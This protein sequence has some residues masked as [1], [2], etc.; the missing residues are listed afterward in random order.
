MRISCIS[1]T[2]GAQS[3][4]NGGKKMTAQEQFEI[5][6][7]DSM[8]RGFP[9]RLSRSPSPTLS[10]SNNSA[11]SPTPTA[12]YATQGSMPTVLTQGTQNGDLDSSMEVVDFESQEPVY[13]DL[14]ECDVPVEKVL[15][16]LTSSMW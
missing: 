7:L 2:Q 9:V 13:P 14:V 3:T 4:E 5:A 11:P 16:Q 6:A 12:S 8:K 10:P 15:H 1:F